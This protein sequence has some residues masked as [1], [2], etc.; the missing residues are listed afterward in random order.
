MILGATILAA[1]PT[2]AADAP[3]DGAALYL[4]FCGACHGPA[5]DG[6]GPVSSRLKTPP[7]RLGTLAARNGGVFPEEYVRKIIDGREER[8]EH[9]MRDMPVWGTFFGMQAQY[10]GAQ[11]A[12][13]ESQVKEKADALV[14]HLKSMQE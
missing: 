1:P 4:K 10:S 2:L 13:T 9:G 3:A 11:G 14:E 5:G 8:K 7:K 12:D 6:D